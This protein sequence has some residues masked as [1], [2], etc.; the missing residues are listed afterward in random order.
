LPT[1]LRRCAHSGCVATDFAQLHVEIST[2]P[3]SG[4]KLSCAAITA[5]VDVSD[6]DKKQDDYRNEDCPLR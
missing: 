5:P 1:E 3:A 2:S 4:I 6:G